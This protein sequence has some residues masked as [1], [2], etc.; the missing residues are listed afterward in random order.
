VT[1]ALLAGR[2]FEVVTP[3]R[4]EGQIALEQL[5]FGSPG[6]IT[7]SNAGIPK[8]RERSLNTNKRWSAGK[9]FIRK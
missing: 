1:A 6:G 5:D 7:G 4:H 8:K 9:N 3:W 2:R